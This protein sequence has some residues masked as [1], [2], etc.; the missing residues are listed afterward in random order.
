MV[1]T[2]WVSPE[3]VVGFQREGWCPDW[4]MVLERVCTS[5]DSHVSDACFWFCS[6]C[7]SDW[8]FIARTFSLSFFSFSAA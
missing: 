7:F 2:D 4:V 5:C 8:A 3:V 6:F 1:V